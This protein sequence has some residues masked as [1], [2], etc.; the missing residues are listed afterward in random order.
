MSITIDVRDRT[1]HTV[2][3]ETDIHVEFARVEEST[4]HMYSSIFS[5]L[6]WSGVSPRNSMLMTTH[7]VLM[8]TALGLNFAFPSD[9]P[10][11]EVWAFLIPATI[12][13]LGYMSRVLP[14]L[15]V[16]ETMTVPV[17]PPTFRRQTTSG[18]PPSTRH[19]TSRISHEDERI[20]RLC[21]VTHHSNMQER[22]VRAIVRKNSP[23]GATVYG[24]FAFVVI[25]WGLR[26]VHR[27][28]DL[29]WEEDY[30]DNRPSPIAIIAIVFV[31]GLGLA[32]YFLFAL[33]GVA[34]SIYLMEQIRLETALLHKELHRRLFPS[35]ASFVVH[36]RIVTRRVC[37]YNEYLG[38]LFILLALNGIVR[39][40]QAILIIVIFVDF[41]AV[42]SLLSNIAILFAVANTAA[43]VNERSDEL[44][45]LIMRD[46][47]W[48]EEG[49]QAAKRYLCANPISAYFMGLRPTPAGIT[50]TIVALINLGVPATY[51]YAKERWGDAGRA[52]RDRYD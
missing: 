23:I 45:A 30:A 32:S 12:G 6:Q 19:R 22:D 5:L 47:L 44:F 51:A 18:G 34:L 27:L 15:R 20:A 46:Q 41:V 9:E 1:R 52:L 2:D 7:A 36:H 43:K 26:V 29:G 10:V 13:A 50:K 24:A 48:D 17:A 25:V 11:F 8:L 37:E 42:A 33:N 39:I 21:S 31:E 16:I 38:P 14:D 4:A 40:L 49:R 28:I 3:V 35:Y